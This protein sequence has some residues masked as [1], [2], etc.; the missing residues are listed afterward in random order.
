VANTVVAHLHDMGAPREMPTEL[1]TTLATIFGVLI[2]AKATVGF[3][4]GW[5]LLQRESWAR[6]V[7]LVLSF[8]ALFNIPFGT[9]IGIY[10]MWVLLP[11]Q[12]QQEYDQLVEDKAA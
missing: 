5:G 10:T 8:L 2:L 12:S 1:L 4:A 9:A 3:I 6:V 7:A 11:G